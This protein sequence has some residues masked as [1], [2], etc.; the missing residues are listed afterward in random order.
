VKAL[1]KRGLGIVFAPYSDH[2]RQMRKICFLELLSAKHIASFA[3]SSTPLR[4]QCA[5]VHETLEGAKQQ[6]EGMSSKAGRR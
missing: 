2:W 3:A 4:P 1:G 5:P 6:Q